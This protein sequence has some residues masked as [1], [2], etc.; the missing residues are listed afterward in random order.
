MDADVEGALEM[1]VVEVGGGRGTLGAVVFVLALL[2]GATGPLPGQDTA[3]VRT[4]NDSVSVRFVDADIRGVIQALGRYLPK[5][6]LVGTIQPVR[7]SLET[8]AP[9]TRGSVRDL[10]KGLVESQNLEFTEDSRFF[11]IGSSRPVPPGGGAG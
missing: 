11:R 7:V 6:V 1:N 10:L 5:P 8:P 4:V 3:T 9:V 2:L